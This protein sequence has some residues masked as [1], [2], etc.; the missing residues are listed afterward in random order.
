MNQL[1]MK[2]LVITGSISFTAYVIMKAWLEI[3]PFIR[4]KEKFDRREKR[5][6]D[7]ALYGIL[8]NLIET[9]KSIVGCLKI[10]ETIENNGRMLGNLDTKFEEFRKS[11]KEDVKKIEK[12]NGGQWK[13]FTQLIKDVSE[14]KGALGVKDGQKN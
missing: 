12:N 1:Y 13:E 3:K 5:G 10:K 4:N 7:D 8:T 9:N 2:F 6:S 11:I 14:I